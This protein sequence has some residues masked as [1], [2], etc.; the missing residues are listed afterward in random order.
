MCVCYWVMYDA[1]IV[2]IDDDHAPRI[3]FAAKDCVCDQICGEILRGVRRRA[4]GSD[5]LI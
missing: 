2:T 3:S 4:S 5:E 1:V